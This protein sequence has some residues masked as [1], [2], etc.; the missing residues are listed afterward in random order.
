MANLP[1]AFK[2]SNPIF[3]EKK[4][5]IFVQPLYDR[6]N[7]S[8]SLTGTYLFFSVPKG[9]SA[10]VIRF[11]TATAT[12]KTIRDTNLPQAGADNNRDYLLYGLSMLLIP[13]AHTPGATTAATIRSDKDY[14]RE[15]GVLNF[16]IGDKQ[17]LD[18]PLTFI[19]ELNAESGA[20][21]TAS[22]TTVYSGAQFSQPYMAFGEEIP[23]NRGEVIS[24][25][26]TWDSTITLSQSFDMMLVFASALRRNS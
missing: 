19:P 11:T 20:S 8:T 22:G 3:D 17:I 26:V 10:T 9:G 4:Q 14:I 2:N 12:N 21:T 16:K 15:G 1:S 6:T 5:E 18:S 24:M 23:L 7:L 25:S 13:A